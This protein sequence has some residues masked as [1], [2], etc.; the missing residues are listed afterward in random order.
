MA[1]R[2]AG[3]VDAHVEPGGASLSDDGGGGLG[4]HQAEFVPESLLRI[5]DLQA[6]D[7]VQLSGGAVG[8]ITASDAAGGHAGFA[9]GEDGR[10][11][12]RGDERLIGADV[13]RGLVF[14][15]VL[16]AGGHDH[17]DAIST[18]IVLGLA[19]KATGGLA[20][21]VL[22]VGVM[23]DGEEAEAR[24]AEVGADGEVLAFADEHVGAGTSVLGRGLEA[25]GG[26]EHWINDRDGLHT[27][28]GAG[29]G[30]RVDV[31]E[32]AEGVD[33]REDDG[34]E[35][36][37]EARGGGGDA[38]GGQAAGVFIGSQEFQFHRG[39]RDVCAEDFEVAG[40]KVGG[41]EHRIRFGVAHA[42][43]A[44][45]GFEERAGAFVERGV[46]GFEAGQLSDRGL[47]NPV[48]DQCA[49]RALRLVGCVGGRQVTDGADVA[50][51]LVGPVD[52]EAITEE[53]GLDRVLLREGLHAI[54]EGLVL[55]LVGEILDAG[56]LHRGV[57]VGIHL[58]EILG[59]D[60]SEHCLDIGFGR[61][62][63]M[64]GELA[65]D[66]RRVV[67]QLGHGCMK[68]FEGGNG[69]RNRPPS[70]GGGIRESRFRHKVWQ[71]IRGLVNKS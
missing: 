9:A 66:F 37:A 64:A 20:D 70:V 16:L 30:E 26:E 52:L 22:L 25:A 65:G 18:G 54:R 68:G 58:R 11:G 15:N 40:Q 10:T 5:A 56:E 14:A 51:D 69:S 62:D 31:L 41:D 23:A 21:F 33:L 50:D 6:R 39:V 28:V 2:A 19:D 67:G 71:P 12:D 44:D 24:A 45:G 29:V 46:D 1:G 8:L 49:L 34:G 48:G 47:V 36:L 43:G 3:D 4:E 7:V 60:G 38:R 17:H 35:L 27:G 61:C 32:Q 57:D 59:A 53:G 63:I 13:R 42:D 55:Q